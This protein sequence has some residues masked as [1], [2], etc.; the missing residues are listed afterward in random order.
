MNGAPPAATG[1]SCG[2]ATALAADDL[3]FTDSQGNT[4]HSFIVL[5]RLKGLDTDPTLKP[6][7]GDNQYVVRFVHGADLSAPSKNVKIS[8]S[9]AHTS[10]HFQ[11][12]FPATV[13]V[14]PDGSYLTTLSFAKSGTWTIHIQ[15]TEGNTEET[16]DYV[17]SL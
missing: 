12:T 6:Q 7:I 5:T 15:L 13:A 11:K 17:V 16:H 8:V 2:G 10:S 9:Y 14:Q 1:A 3:G 4:H